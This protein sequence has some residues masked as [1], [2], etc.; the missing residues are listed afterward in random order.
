V[1]GHHARCRGPFRRLFP[2][3]RHGR[4]QRPSGRIRETSTPMTSASVPTTS[5]GSGHGDSTRWAWTRRRSSLRRQHDRV[6]ERPRPQRG[7]RGVL[8]FQ[9]TGHQFDDHRWPVPPQ[10]GRLPHR[11]HAHAR[12]REDGLHRPVVVGLGRSSDSGRV[13]SVL[14]PSD[15]PASAPRNEDT[16]QLSRGPLPRRCSCQGMG[17]AGTVGPSGPQK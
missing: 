5:L 7:V 2:P 13:G 12:A 3:D 11:V 4:L 10:P 1:E 14:E 6:D 15:A 8:R 16:P 9:W 17:R